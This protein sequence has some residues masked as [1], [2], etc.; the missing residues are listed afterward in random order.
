MLFRKPKYVCKA[1]E[2]S[3]LFQPGGEVMACHYNRGYVLGLYPNNSIHDIWFGKK[4]SNLVKS[5]RSGKF[6]TSCHFC[7]SA[8]EQNL[9]HKAGINKYDYIIPDKHKMPVSMEFQLDNIC[10]L[11]CIMCSGEYSS[12]IRKNREKGEPYYSPYDDNF[13]DQLKPF[14]PYLNQASFTGGEPFLFE[15]YY[16]IWDLMKVL[17]PDIKLYISSNGTVLNDRVKSYLE[18]LNFNLTISID[19]LNKNNY[20]RIRKNAILENSL[21]NINYYIEYCKRKGM[22][23]NIKSLVTP[24]NYKDIAEL[25]EFCNHNQINF[26]PKTVLVPGFANFTFS[27]T[28]EVESAINLLNNLVKESKNDI[29]NQNYNRIIEIKIELDNIKNCQSEP[30]LE[31]NSIST[32]RLKTVLIENILLS[33]KLAK[34]NKSDDYYREKLN[35]LF[36]YSDNENELRTAIISFSQIPPDILISEFNRSDI[37][38]LCERFKQSGKSKV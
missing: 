27:D 9:I 32:E 2:Y 16:K 8:I 30:K 18:Q 26:I 12:Q 36:S 21:E 38:K 20:E 3:L 7:K 28:K 31:E 34:N 24:Q 6:E 10:N 13:V 14:I 37:R 17:N 35:V 5:I 19:S 29:N 11:E 1:A 23:F 25:L 22:T 4:R 33:N 15:I